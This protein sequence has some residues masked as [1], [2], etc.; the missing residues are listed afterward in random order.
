[1]F[2]EQSLRE[3][4][5]VVKAFTGLPAEAFWHLVREVEARQPAYERERRARPD[6]RRAVGGGRPFD[7]PLAIRVALVLTY[8]RLHVPQEAVAHLYGTTQSDVSR[9]LRRL[10][11]LLREVLPVPQVWEVVAADTPLSE[12][13]RLDLADLA[14]G[15]ALIDATEQRVYRSQESTERKRHYSGKKR[16]SP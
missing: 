1:M 13:E 10:L 16:P 4:P 8:L 5:A 9:E 6:R 11:P 12:A 15:R 3:H 14:D 7:Q 2:T